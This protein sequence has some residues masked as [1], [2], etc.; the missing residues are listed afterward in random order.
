MQQA[1]NMIHVDPVQAPPIVQEIPE[2]NDIPDLIDIPDLNESFDSGICMDT[3]D[4]ESDEDIEGD[5]LQDHE[6]GL[7]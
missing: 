3:S 6:L 7:L 2:D 4:D 1:F 5:F